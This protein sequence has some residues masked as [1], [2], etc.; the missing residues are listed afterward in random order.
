MPWLAAM[1]VTCMFFSAN[2]A[3]AQ[4]RAQGQ[5]RPLSASARTNAEQQISALMADKAHWT[6]TQSKLDTQ[7]IF[8]ARL[9]KPAWFTRRR[10]SSGRP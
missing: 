3:I 5:V 7:L 2:K 9:K 4:V 1:G 8:H 10:P 6:K